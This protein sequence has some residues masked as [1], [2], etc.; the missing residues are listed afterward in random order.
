MGR[1][2][3]LICK[4]CIFFLTL[5]LLR[6][7]ARGWTCTAISSVTGVQ[8]KM[9]TGTSKFITSKEVV[10]KKSNTKK[11]LSSLAMPQNFEARTDFL[12]LGRI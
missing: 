4:S 5:I 6:A 2:K 7:V 3:S 12:T 9:L 1:K 8:C 10:Q 11:I